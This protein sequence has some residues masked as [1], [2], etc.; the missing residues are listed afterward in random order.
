MY[1]YANVKESFYIS[2]T[3]FVGKFNGIKLLDEKDEENK[4]H[5]AGS[6]YKRKF[7]IPSEFLPAGLMSGRAISY[8]EF[9]SMIQC[10]DF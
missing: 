10:Y 7:D 4:Y 3:H 1:V 8:N 2:Y 9:G 5:E 6:E